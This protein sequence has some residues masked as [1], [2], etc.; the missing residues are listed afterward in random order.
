MGIGSYAA[1]QLLK[2]LD[3]YIPGPC[4]GNLRY[5]MYVD[6]FDRI[7]SYEKA[8]FLGFLYADGYNVISQKSS[9]NKCETSLHLHVKDRSILEY[10][11]GLLYKGLVKPI[12]SLR[13]R[14][15][16]DAC[17]LKFRC[18][19]ISQALWNIGMQNDKT[20]ESH[21]PKIDDE[22]IPSFIL[23][24][25]DGDGCITLQKRVWASNPS[26]SGVSAVVDIISNH[27]IIDEMVT[28][29][30]GIGINFKTVE[31]SNPHYLHMYI[32]SYDDV[33]RFYD[34]VYAHQKI[35]L[36]R[37]HD[38]FLEFFALTEKKRE[39][40]DRLGIPPMH[41]QIRHFST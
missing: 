37:K 5:E 13:R 3:I 7:D 10:F 31:H 41:Q 33:K 6:Y 40:Q 9:S 12:I 38:R 32:C 18:R 19:Q 14:D 21:L 1:T 27:F 26:I 36:S 11:H 4:I 24:Y 39:D 23:G 35:F 25:F 16:G 30:R 34:C 8:Y 22:F 28:W 17:V 15:G 2:S 29:L 20:Y